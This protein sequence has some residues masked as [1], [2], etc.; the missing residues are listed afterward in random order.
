MEAILWN[1][2]GEQSGKVSL[3]KEIFEVQGNAQFLHEIVTRYL[4]NQRQWSANTK[5]RSE[6]SGGGHKPWKQKHTGRARAGSNRSPLWRHG[7]IAMG[8][9]VVD[10]QF[11]RL[12]MPRRKSRLALTQALSARAADGGLRII[13]ALAVENPKT[14]QMAELLKKLGAEKKPLLVIDHFDK[15]LGVAGRN[16]PGLQV[17]LVSNLNA[18]QVLRCGALVMTQAAV[19]KLKSRSN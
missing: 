18:Y 8:P 1:K 17:A 5:T 11:K 6:V 7:G 4:A 2:K 15:N 14:K 13:E 16:I 9:R 3:P 10:L 19:E 12:D